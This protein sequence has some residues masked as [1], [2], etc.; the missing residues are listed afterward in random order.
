M[1]AKRNWKSHAAR[2]GTTNTRQSEIRNVQY[3]ASILHP[4]RRHIDVLG[5]VCVMFF[6]FV[7]A[8]TKNNNS[9]VVRW[10]NQFTLGTRT[11]FETSPKTATTTDHPTKRATN[12]QPSLKL[13]NLQLRCDKIDDIIPSIDGK[14]NFTNAPEDRL[15]VS[16]IA[17]WKNKNETSANGK[18]PHHTTV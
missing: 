17:P 12:L 9:D 10:G 8:A 11:F 13:A 3:I 14:P 18:Y 7:I 15:S 4:S 16:Q 5:T 1:W 2:Q 6:D